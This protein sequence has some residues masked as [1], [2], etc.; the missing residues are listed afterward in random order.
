[1]SYVYSAILQYQD[2]DGR[3][4][5]LTGTP[6]V[7]AYDL[8]G[9]SIASPSITNIATGVYKV[10]VSNNDLEDVLFRVVPHVD[11]QANFDD[12][13][14]MQ[15][16]V[17]H[18]ADDI[19]VDTGTTLPAVLDAIKGAGWTDETLVALKTAI[20]A[21]VGGA[22]AQEVWEYA[23]RTL[24]QSATSITSAVSGSTISDVR[25]DTWDIDIADVTLDA[26]KQ[27]FAIKYTNI[28]TDAEALL[29]ID[30]DTGLLYLNG[31]AV[32]VADQGKASL[33]YAGTTLT[34][35]V[36]AS[37]TAQLPK[38]NWRYGIQSVTAAGVV[39]EG[40][41]GTFTVTADTV[42]ATA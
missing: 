37:I 38:G 27:Q 24:T 20:D 40:Y 22:T 11:D 18:V 17:Y 30:S 32:E 42:R 2:S 28:D 16:K 7:T 8:A 13:A 12:V 35:A 1:M 21:I 9:N 5:N 6:T 3:F 29:L 33:S 41:G 10:S 4:A 31:A 14:V 26:N 23:T 36:D 39:N 19:L 25:G 15:E 34:V